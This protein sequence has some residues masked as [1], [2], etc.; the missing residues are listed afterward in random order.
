MKITNLE[1]VMDVWNRIKKIDQEI[2]KIEKQ[3]EA[4]ADA[5]TTI[6]LSLSSGHYKE[7]GKHHD[8]MDAVEYMRHAMRRSYGDVRGWSAEYLATDEASSN[9]I[10]MDLDPSQ[11][12][13]V[14]AVLIASKNKEKKQL[15][16]V[17]RKEGISI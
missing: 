2:M 16:N 4:F 3:A 15:L 9:E 6:S 1:F 13:E 11:A 14:L 17:L 12:L 10:E 7:A 8:A 5:D